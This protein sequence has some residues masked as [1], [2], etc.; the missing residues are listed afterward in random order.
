M[1]IEYNACRSTGVIM[2]ILLSGYSPFDDPNEAILFQKIKKG[3]YSMKEP[4]WESVTYEGT[5]SCHR[6]WIH[7]SELYL[8]NMGRFC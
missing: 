5:S 4:V 1:S 6:H 8:H 3:M 2:Y 7:V